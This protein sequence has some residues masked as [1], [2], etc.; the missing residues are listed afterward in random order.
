[1]LGTYYSLCDLGLKLELKG[2]YS[3]RFKI[4]KTSDNV[5]FWLYKT[6]IR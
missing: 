2:L 3:A 6:C 1:M 4:D 5:K